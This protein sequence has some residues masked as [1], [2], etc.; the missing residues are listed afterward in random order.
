MIMKLI[1]FISY[2]IKRILLKKKEEKEIEIEKKWMC[3]D[4]LAKILT[5]KVRIKKFVLTSSNQ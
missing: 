5:N 2:E 3:N 4:S 1:L